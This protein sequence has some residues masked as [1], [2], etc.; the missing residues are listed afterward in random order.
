M[1]FKRS[2]VLIII[3]III[4]FW[5]FYYLYYY[6][7]LA[8]SL[9]DLEFYTYKGEKYSLN[10]FKGKYVFLNLFTS[11][12]GSCSVELNILN[13]LNNMCINKDFE[14]VS[15]MVDREGIPLLPQIVSSHNL[16]YIVGIAPSDIFRFFPDLSLTPTTYILNQQGYLVEKITGY[17]SF[18]GWLKILKK[19]NI[20]CN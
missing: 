11:Y 18:N 1:R 2:L 7:P 14:I 20:N 19:Y 13:K 9:V 8:S 12:C 3:T 15:L 17:K 16:T 6:K 4:T 10:N 5:I